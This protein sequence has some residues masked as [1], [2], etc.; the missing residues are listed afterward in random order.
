MALERCKDVVRGWDAARRGRGHTDA[1]CGGVE[2]VHPH[3]HLRWAAQLPTHPAGVLSHWHGSHWQCWH[4][5]S[6]WC[7]WHSP[8]EPLLSACCRGCSSWEASKGYGSRRDQIVR[9]TGRA[10]PAAAPCCSLLPLLPLLPMVIACTSRTRRTSPLP[11]TVSTF[12]LHCVEGQGGGAAG[13]SVEAGA[14]AALACTCCGTRR[15]P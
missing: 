2:R 8:V 4:A 13:R 3:D 7:A 15:T 5:R 11:R 6:G 12:T 1:A 9:S 14:E 10:G